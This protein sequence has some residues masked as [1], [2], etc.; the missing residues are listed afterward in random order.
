MAEDTKSIIEKYIGLVK[1]E[2]F[3]ELY[4][5]MIDCGFYDAPASGGFHCSKHGGLAEHTLNVI[6]TAESLARTLFTEKTYDKMLESVIISAFLH[7]LG[8][9]GDYD[10]QYYVDNILKSGNQS[11]SKPF[12]RNPDLKEIGHAIRSLCIA[13]RFIDLTEDEEFAIRFHDGLYDRTN[14][15]V[16][17]NETPLYIIIHTADLWSS[18]IIEKKEK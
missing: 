14:Y 3:D 2:G 9:L 11:D 15:D 13:N 12:K 10:K 17:G 4:D 8:K 18:Q 7:D 16:Q 1:R 5:Y 6:I